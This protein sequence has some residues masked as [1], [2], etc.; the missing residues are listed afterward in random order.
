MKTLIFGIVVILIGIWIWLSHFGI[1]FISFRRDWPVLIILL[2][3]WMILK[4]NRSRRLKVI[5]EL[6]KGSIDVDEAVDKL[7]RSK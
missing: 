3:I 7:R 4:R 2:G 5:K 6:E 1:A